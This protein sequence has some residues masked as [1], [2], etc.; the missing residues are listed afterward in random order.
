MKLNSLLEKN[1][2]RLAPMAGVSNEP[3]RMIC[4]ENG[5]GFVTSEEIDSVSLLY[6]KSER[7]NLIT[8]F[9]KL[10]KPIAMQ[11]LGCDP[12]SL[13]ESS[14]ILQ[15]LGASIIDINM[16]CPVP[17]ITK[18]GKGAALMKDIKKTAILI[19]SIRKVTIVPLTVKIRSGWDD[20]NINAVEFAEMLQS[21][22]VDGITVH[23]RTKSQRY[24]GKSKW[25]IIRDVVDK[26][27]IPVT[28][29]GDV[30]SY[31]TA[32]K[33]MNFTNCKSVMVGRGAIGNP[34][35]FNKEFNNYAAEEKELY[36]KKTIIKHIEL[37]K[38]YFPKKNLDL[39]IK[40][41][42]AYYTK[43]FYN[44]RELRQKIFQ[45]SNDIQKIISLFFDFFD[46]NIEAKTFE[47]IS[48]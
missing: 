37:M 16:G 23:P 7:T 2:T 19:R 30:Q 4:L 47:K 35:I 44:S 40:K 27:S 41:N 14:K 5:S 28:G 3:F 42:L 21:E 20:K 45:N 6:N 13:S 11:L 43:G 29:N 48:I 24:E 31:E 38:E 33:M 17:K 9:S 22:G 1:I 36:K 15:D 10:E 26:V 25:S 34:W 46:K 18:K 12:L 39:E 8:Q 32:K